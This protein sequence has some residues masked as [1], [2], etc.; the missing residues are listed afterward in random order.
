M[1]V[2]LI[3]LLIRVI[4]VQVIVQASM[5][6]ICKIMKM[7]QIVKSRRNSYNHCVCLH[8]QRSIALLLLVHRVLL[9][10]LFPHS[11]HASVELCLLKLKMCFLLLVVLSRTRYY[12]VRIRFASFCLIMCKILCK[13]HFVVQELTVKLSR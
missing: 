10:C 3:V 1:K 13:P 5:T 11:T 4:V 7:Q 12:R 9:L 6:R 2:L 8:D